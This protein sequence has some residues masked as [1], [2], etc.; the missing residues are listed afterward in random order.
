MHAF[1][2]CREMVILFVGLMLISS[3][4]LIFPSE[5]VD[6]NSN[7]EELCRGM[8]GKAICLDPVSCAFA[9]PHNLLSIS[10]IPQTFL[11]SPM[12]SSPLCSWCL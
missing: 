10:S 9:Q 2:C 4:I 8:R 3:S 11:F 12:G 5:K 6:V 7:V 1:L